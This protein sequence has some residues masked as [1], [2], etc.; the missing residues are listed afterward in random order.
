MAVLG[1]TD[2]ESLFGSA[3]QLS[4]CLLFLQVGL[5]LA[6]VRAA[7][8][9]LVVVVWRWPQREPGLRAR[10]SQ[11]PQVRLDPPRQ[12]DIWTVCRGGLPL[13]APPCLLGL[14]LGLGRVGEGSHR[15][16]G[17]SE[18]P[19]CPERA[20][21]GFAY[22]GSLPD[23]GFWPREDCGLGAQR[24]GAHRPSGVRRGDILLVS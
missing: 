1:L 9:L 12:M 4:C 19:G 6:Q 24:P 16:P 22:E 15:V 10:G 5:E 8:L 17:L 13:W 7:D 14:G 23:S 18:G 20:A 3:S 21:V 11:E 2:G